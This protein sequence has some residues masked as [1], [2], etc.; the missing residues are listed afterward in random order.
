VG[1]SSL[2]YDSQGRLFWTFLRDPGDV[3]IAQC[4]PNTGAIFRLPLNV[5]AAPGW[6]RFF[7]A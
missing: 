2:G 7:E 4:N 5:T 1:D 3:F 6:G